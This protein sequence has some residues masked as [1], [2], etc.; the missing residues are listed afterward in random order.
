MPRRAV[1]LVLAVLGLAGCFGGDESSALED[2]TVQVNETLDD[3][4]PAL[5]RAEFAFRRYSRFGRIGDADV[6]RLRSAASELR[7]AHTRIEL[8]DPPPEARRLHADILQLL[9]LDA[10]FALELSLMATYVPRA[11]RALATTQGVANDFR[12]RLAAGKTAAAQARAL[13]GYAAALADIAARLRRLVAPPVLQPW[14]RERL[15]QLSRTSRLSRE[16]ASALA[17]GNRAELIAAAEALQRPGPSSLAAA[18]R[19]ATAAFNRRLTRSRV[20]FGKIY[21]QH[22]DLL[23]EEEA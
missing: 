12:T 10:N 11:A 16:L 19:R 17:G 3:S 18:Q 8:V 20:L 14:H 5:A 9:E 23:A 4:R 7:A 21:R 13:R 6:R 1:L 2:Y 22:Q 15:Q